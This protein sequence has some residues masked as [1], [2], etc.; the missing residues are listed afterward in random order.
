MS[1]VS[2]GDLQTAFWI[3]IIRYASSQGEQNTSNK[4]HI[5]DFLCRSVY[6]RLNFKS[7]KCMFFK[8]H[9]EARR[10]DGYLLPVTLLPHQ[11]PLRCVHT[12]RTGTHARASACASLLMWR[13]SRARAQGPRFVG[14][15]SSSGSAQRWCI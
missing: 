13:F 2:T 8:L 14:V 1:S 4:F 11:T 3:F 5:D 7:D 10:K 9:E 12:T 6:S 15:L